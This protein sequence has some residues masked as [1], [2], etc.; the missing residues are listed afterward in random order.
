MCNLILSLLRD[1][2]AK[3]DPALTLVYSKANNV[4]TEH[5]DVPIW[6][7]KYI[8]GK[9]GENIKYM[10]QDL[11]KV[12][13]DFIDESINVEGSPKE[14]YKACK[15]LKEMIDTLRYQVPYEEVEVNPVFHRRIIV[16]SDS[17]VVLKGAKDF[18]EPAKQRLHEI[19]EDL[20]AM[21]TFECII[22]Q[23]HHPTVLG[24]RGSKKQN[25]ST[26]V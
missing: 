20:E 9:K 6:L 18:L 13:V 21:V 22:S 24:T 2:K 15:R 11:S 12:Q 16:V 7:H 23:E 8:I 25:N 10:T 5:M 4:K 26:I 19:V 14:V 1:E 17:K 3:L